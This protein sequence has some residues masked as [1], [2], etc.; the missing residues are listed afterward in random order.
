LSEIPDIGVPIMHWGEKRL[1][2]MLRAAAEVAYQRI[3]IRLVHAWA[4]RLV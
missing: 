2:G 3:I 1:A 4:A